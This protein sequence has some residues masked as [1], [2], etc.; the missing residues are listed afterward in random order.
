[1][2][3]REAPY[4][5]LIFTTDNKNGEVL[6]PEQTDRSI[7]IIVDKHWVHLIMYDHFMKDKGDISNVGEKEVGI[8]E[9]L[10][11]KK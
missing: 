5:P 11:G 1:M 8:T 9:Q 4:I 6:V 2:H 3:F 10:F 7:D